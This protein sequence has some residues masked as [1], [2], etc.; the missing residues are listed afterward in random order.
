MQPGSIPRRYPRATWLAIGLALAFGAGLVEVYW[1]EIFQALVG[2]PLAWDL[3]PPWVRVLMGIVRWLP[4]IVLAGL[5]VARIRIGPAVRPLWFFA[6]IAA[7]HLLLVA[8]V[9]GQPIVDDLSHRQRFEPVAWRANAGRDTRWPTRL[10]MVDDLLRRRDLH[11]WTRPQVE[12]LLGP[13][14]DTGYFRDWDMV[15]NLGPERGFI[16]LDDE[17]LVVRLGADGTVTDYRI[18]AD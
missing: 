5:V 9:L 16:S 12:R 2:R 4:W 14:D 3:R 1:Q 10:R 15:Y 6:G 7:N 18:V 17:W 13:A 8:F 11:G